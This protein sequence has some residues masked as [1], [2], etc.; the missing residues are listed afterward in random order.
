MKAYLFILGSRDQLA[1]ESSARFAHDAGLTI[2]ELII[3]DSLAERAVSKDPSLLSLFDQQAEYMA[4]ASRPRAVQA[5]LAFAGVDV[6]SKPITWKSLPFSEQALKDEYGVPWFPVIDRSH[7]TGCGTCEDYCLFSVYTINRQRSL[8]ERV[9]VAAPLNCKT[10]C[11]ACSRLCPTGALIFP[12]CAEP[13]LNGSIENPQPRTHED[14]LTALG[15]D[16]HKVLAE[17]RAKKR[18]IDPDKFQMAE[19]DRIL[20]SGVL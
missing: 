15:T 18:L 10:G 7:C 9:C 16:P 14:A 12:F 20:Y 8:S 6:Y 1:Q 5:L 13:L 3:I 19:K 4:G 11:P 2:E 17:R